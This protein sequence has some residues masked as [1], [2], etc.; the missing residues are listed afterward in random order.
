MIFSVFSLRTELFSNISFMVG[1]VLYVERV[2]GVF[3]EVIRGRF[4]KRRGC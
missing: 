2:G 4:K 1:L 3:K